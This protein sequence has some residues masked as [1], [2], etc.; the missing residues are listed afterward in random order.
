MRSAIL[1]GAAF[2]LTALVP[3]AL[4]QPPALQ[5]RIETHPLWTD[6]AERSIVLPEEGT[7]ASPLKVGARIFV[8]GG[9]F[10]CL[11][12]TA[13]SFQLGLRE[14]GP[15]WGAAR[16]EPEDA[17]EITYDVPQG[18]QTTSNAWTFTDGP[19]FSVAW[20]LEDAPDNAT[21]EYH[22]LGLGAARLVSGGCYPDPLNQPTRHIDETVNVTKPY[23]P[24]APAPTFSDGAS[25]LG[26]QPLANEE[27]P[28]PGAVALFA[29]LGVVSWLRKGRR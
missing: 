6:L 15:A 9:A 26:T 23:V 5:P 27:S 7:F 20:R 29:A 3:Q 22:I 1:L 18:A 2:L 16:L 14:P 12:D 11:P 24:P 10:S 25:P 13:Y 19:S 28:T 17:T 8:S 4:A 21:F